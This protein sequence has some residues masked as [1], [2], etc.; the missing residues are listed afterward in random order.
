MILVIMQWF[1]LPSISKAF[2]ENQTNREKFRIQRK[3]R[4]EYEKSPAKILNLEIES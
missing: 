4:R 3:M 2:E 1:K